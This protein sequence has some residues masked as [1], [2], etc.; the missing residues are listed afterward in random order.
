MNYKRRI[1]RILTG[2]LFLLLAHVPQLTHAQI[3]DGIKVKRLLDGA[4][5][6]LAKDSATT[7]SD[8]IY[9]NAALAGK[10]DTPYQV[11]NIITLTINEYSTLLLPDSFRVTANLRIYYTLADLSVDSVDQSLSINYD[12]AK[13]Y[14]MRSS[15]VFDGSHQVKV[16]IL[17]ITSTASKD[18]LPALMILNEMEVH[19]VYKLSCTADAVKKVYSNNPAS[20]DTTDELQVS[21]DVMTGADV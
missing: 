8:S 11:K 20:T 15:F 4:R 10:L 2:A 7:A 14:T 19:P 1:L 9:F 5:G 16:K 13:T 17:G 6:Q 3:K 18:V 21:W 12:T